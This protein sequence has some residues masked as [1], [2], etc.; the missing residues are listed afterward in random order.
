LLVH[1]LDKDTSGCILVAKNREGAAFFSR[2]F[3]EEKLSE[4]SEKPSRGRPG[5]GGANL[6]KQYLAVCA[7]R[8]RGEA[9]VI[10]L[11]IEIRG[12]RKKS[13]TRYRRLSGGLLPRAP[14]SAG[15]YSLLEI[16]PGTGRMHQ[17]RRHLAQTGN[18][19][20]GDDKYGNF[21]LNKELR[22]TMKLKR[23]LLHAFRLIIPAIGGFPGLDV[24]APP[25]DYFEPFRYT[26]RVSVL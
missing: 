5:C 16:E 22:R 20:L 25:P 10:R 23:L 24:T 21:R 11:D 6:V 17:I 1:R 8:L 26:F 2:L 12:R 4:T 3:G 7:G 14:L 9:G 19:V 18:P 15:E 13:E